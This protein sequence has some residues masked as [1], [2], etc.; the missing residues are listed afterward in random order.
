MSICMEAFSQQELLNCVRLWQWTVWSVF[1]ETLHIMSSRRIFVVLLQQNIKTIVIFQSSSKCVVLCSTLWQ[2]FKYLCTVWIV[3]HSTENVFP[4][5][6]MC[7]P[8][9][10]FLAYCTE[11]TRWIFTCPNR[12]DSWDVPPPTV[13]LFLLPLSKPRSC[14]QNKSFLCM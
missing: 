9:I 4:L 14:W 3:L 10:R 13:P 8:F 1:V 11:Q 12:K 5:D 6:L 2:V 7:G